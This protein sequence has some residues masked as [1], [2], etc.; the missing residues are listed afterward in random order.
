MSFTVKHG[1]RVS[2]LD[3]SGGTFDQRCM[4][5]RRALLLVLSTLS[6]G[7][8]ACS[9]EGSKGNLDAAVAGFDA[10]IFA[11]PTEQDANLDVA[12]V[13]DA[14]SDVVSDAPVDGPVR[15]M[16][17]SL[18]CLNESTAQRCEP[19]GDT[20]RDFVCTNGCSE[21]SCN[22]SVFSSGWSAY[23]FKTPDDDTAQ[24]LAGYEVSGNDLI[25]TQTSN[26]M[27][28][29]YLYNRP[30]ENVEITGNFGV[31]TDVDNDLVG[32]VLGWQDPEHFYLFDWKQAT[33]V[34]SCGTA[35]EGGAL[36][37]VKAAAA[38]SMCVDFWNSTGSTRV[39]TV[40][41]PAKNVVG[42]KDNA[43]YSFRV[44]F[45]PGDIRIEIKEGATTVVSIVSKDTTYAK[46][47]FGFYGYSQEAVRYDS[48]RLQPASSL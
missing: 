17:N 29:A 2:L 13:R 36:K 3:F 11:K 26:A 40:S 6:I 15:C 46:G 5:N 33:Q 41:D 47:Q 18:R 9:D 25:V 30:L 12:A 21:N 27:P 32:F 19:T 34:T 10:P 7:V 14:T 8:S 48:I 37:V 1:L 45:R 42:W 24:G 31:F 43:N 39:K 22:A 20:W 44:V 16:P 28:A 35:N 23:Q 4:R 38:L